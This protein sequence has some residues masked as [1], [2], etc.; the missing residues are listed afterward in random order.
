MCQAREIEI[1]ECRSLLS[2]Y[3]SKLP[4]LM[5]EGSKKSIKATNFAIRGYS[6][7][8]KALQEREAKEQENMI[9]KA[10]EKLE[11]KKQERIQENANKII[12]PFNI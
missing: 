11:A 10:L 4:T 1:D 7:I 12:K 6:V 3:I 2:G 5:I 8:E 9:A